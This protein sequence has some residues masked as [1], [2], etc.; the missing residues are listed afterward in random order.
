MCLDYTTGEDEGDRAPIAG[1][2]DNFGAANS[3]VR[4]AV[5]PASQDTPNTCQ[6]CHNFG[7]A[8]PVTW[9]M[10]MADGSVHSV[11]YSLDV[12]VH[13]ILASIDGQEAANWPE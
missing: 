2:K 8:H 6:A 9:N 10:S 1:L 4:F 11:S 5:S 3:F 12:R 7:S 13:R